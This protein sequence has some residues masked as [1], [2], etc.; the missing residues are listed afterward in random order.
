MKTTFSRRELYAFGEPF[1]NSATVKKLGGCVYGGGGD[2]LLGL[3]MLATVAYFTGGASLGFDLAAEAGA[4]AVA[5]GAA[6]TVAAESTAAFATEALVGEAL[7]GEALLAAQGLGAATGEALGGEALLAAQGLGATEA[8]Q[9]AVAANST[10]TDQILSQIGN[11]F[12]RGAA[13]SG[14]SS[15]LSGNT[16]NLLENM[17]VG[18]I[19]G[20]AG[21]GAGAL[22]TEAFGANPI[23]SGAAQGAVGAG[24]GAVLN[25]S[26]D[27]L[28]AM[29]KGLIS[30]GAGGA[31][32]LV[33]DL[34][35]GPLASG[36]LKG[37]IQGGTGAV[38]NGRNVLSGAL[39]GGVGGA[40]GSAVGNTVGQ[41]TGNK[42]LSSVLG[43]AAGSYASSQTANALNGALTIPGQRPAQAQTMGNAASS[44]PTTQ[45]YDN[46]LV[47]KNSANLGGQ[48]GIPSQALGKVLGTGMPSEANPLMNTGTASNSAPSSGLNSAGMPAPLASG[49]LTSQAPA[50]SEYAAKVA[51]M[52]QIYPQLAG[53]DP[54]IMNS[55]VSN[56][57]QQVQT[58]KKG[59]GASSSKE[60]GEI[61]GLDYG[62]NP[63][64][65]TGSTGHYVK[66][67]GDGQSDD[68]PA[69]LADGE[70]VF[71]AD[72]VASLGNGSSDAGARLLDHFRESLREH[73]R[74]ASSDKIPPEASPLAYMKEALKRHK[75]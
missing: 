12:V 18:G 24:T 67:K 61:Y 75:G 3:V 4:A 41:A 32:N 66:G 40:A 11:G 44:T 47:G 42:L 49:V 13:T 62:H 72:S 25:G 27:V 46:P 14:A 54:R 10:A 59:G 9:A 53:V 50:A 68:I 36:A 28:G 38:L 19:S 22:T 57:P 70:Y 69:M 1:G 31:S 15:V 74:S 60:G 43:G 73:K 48:T 56:A 37:A 7:G 58:Y 17:I 5:E 6:A 55:L 29:T 8:A 33:K 23:L 71:D 26:P 52:T 30:G 65:I 20:G 16:D 34:Q 2:G 45:N 35:L 63:Q 51:Q 39:S 64:F 21:A